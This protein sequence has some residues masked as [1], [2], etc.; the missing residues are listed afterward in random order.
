MAVGDYVGPVE[1]TFVALSERPSLS[2]DTVRTV[3]GSYTGPRLAPGE[4]KWQSPCRTGAHAV[5]F[6]ANKKGVFVHEQ[7]RKA[8]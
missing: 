3:L 7:V 1:R 4:A 8:K 6:V 5:T 2:R